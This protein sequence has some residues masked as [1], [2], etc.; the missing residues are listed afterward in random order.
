M[1]G[2]FGGVRVVYCRD[3]VEM[4]W[5]WCRDEVE[6]LGIIFLFVVLQKSV[7]NCPLLS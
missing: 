5:R 1:G 7:K 4:V 6:K 3:G 2:R